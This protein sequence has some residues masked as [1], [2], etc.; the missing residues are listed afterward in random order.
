M[1]PFETA[2]GTIHYELLEATGSNGEVNT[3]TLLHNF[4]SS[5]RSAWGTLLEKLNVNHRILLPDLPGHGRSIGHPIGFH[6]LEMALQIAGLMQE[7][8]A[9]A[10]HLAGCSSGGMIAQLLVH[11]KIVS[12]ATL[13]LISTTHSVDPARIRADNRLQPENFR[14]GKGW[15]EATAKLHDPYQYEGYYEEIL[16]PNFRRLTGKTAI[17][18]P[19]EEL[20][21]W[22]L[23]VCLIHGAEDEFFPKAVP[24]SMFRLLPDAELHLIPKQSH[25]LI[26][27]RPWQVADIISDFLERHEQGSA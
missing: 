23:P 22:A 7:V 25:A 24:E 21:E 12:P 17:D 2:T 11:H 9:D 8:G 20:Q 14:A 6:H 1:P 4:M 10:D 19:L 15:M 26:F 5:G 13:T 27:R 18:L 16:L 3:L